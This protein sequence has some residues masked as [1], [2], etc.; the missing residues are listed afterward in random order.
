MPV[1]EIA[2]L[3]RRAGILDYILSYSCKCLYLPAREV[4]NKINV[5]L[6]NK[7]AKQIVDN[8]FEL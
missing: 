5:I 7:A 6:H 4:W 3:A 1:L 8:M 2:E